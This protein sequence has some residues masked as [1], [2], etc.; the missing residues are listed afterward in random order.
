MRNEHLSTRTLLAGVLGVVMGGFGCSDSS[1]DAAGE[2]AGGAGAS[3]GVAAVGSGGSVMT[4][5][6][7]PVTG[8]ATASAGMAT[9]GSGD[10]GVTPTGGT[11][12]D[13]TGSSG[14]STAA[15][16]G[17]SPVGGATSSGGTATGGSADGGALP[18]GATGGD[19]TGSSGGSIAAMGGMSP[20]GGAT[21]SG[22]TAGAAGAMGGSSGMSGT[23]GSAMGSGG[24]GGWSGEGGTGTSQTC[25]TMTL[26]TGDTRATLQF[27]GLTRTYLVYVPSS[28]E[29]GVAVPL[30]LDFHGNGGTSEQ[31][32]ASSGWG[33]KADEVG[34]IVAYP[35]GVG[36]AWN[37]GV[38][39]GEALAGNVDDVGFAR[40]IIQ[41][42]S[43]QACIDPKRVYAT[44]MSNG[45]GMVHRLA[46]EA[47][48]VIAAIAAASSDLVTDPCTPARP[49]SELSVRGLDDTLVAYEGGN[50][51]STGWYSPGAQGTL[52]LWKEINECTGTV[53]PT[54]QYCETYSSCSAGTEVTLCSL[55]NTGHDTYA[56]GVGFSV[57][58]VAWE[59]FERQPMP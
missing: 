55:P 41:A 8:G 14:G 4:G 57:P 6:S 11:G 32:R 17:M 52:E 19:E 3:G 25:P 16:G 31:Q 29:P 48:D 5:G 1:A 26:A 2:S 20:V 18:T 12:G 39:C 36:N 45:A 58:D 38:C 7:A 47:A 49:I 9:G 28:I 34:C 27:G 13:E 42:V 10:A 59:M 35:D 51:G 21:S 53:E 22:G 33:T 44:G 43:E 23:G 50:T 46:C 30:V 56:N 40:A 37:V 15:L 24:A 54:L